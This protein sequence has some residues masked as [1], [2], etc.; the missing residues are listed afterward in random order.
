MII[1]SRYD[2]RCKD[3]VYKVRS[4]EEIPC[5]KCKFRL[6]CIGSRKR[7][8]IDVSGVRRV[9]SIRRLRCMRCH[10]IHHELPDLFIPYHLVSAGIIDLINSGKV[11]AVPLDLTSIDR[12]SRWWER[13]KEYTSCIDTI[14]IK[15]MVNENLILH[16]CFM[17][18]FYEK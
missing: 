16:T 4:F 6:E 2:V 14:G 7:K 5:P 18:T 8:L 10:K 11:N 1:I 12:L 17:D 9:Y 15:D 3:G 13:F